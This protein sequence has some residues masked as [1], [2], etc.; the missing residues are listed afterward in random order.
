MIYLIVIWRIKNKK[1][2][3]LDSPLAGKKRENAL[4]ETWILIKGDQAAN[5]AQCCMI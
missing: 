4:L 5:R 3:V 1:D 2:Y